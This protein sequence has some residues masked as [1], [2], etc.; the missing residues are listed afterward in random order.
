[1]VQRMEHYRR[2]FRFDQIQFHSAWG[3]IGIVLVFS[4]CIRLQ[5]FV[6][7]IEESRLFEGRGHVLVL[8]RFQ[9]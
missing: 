9:E 8:G 3:N 5:S 1:M 4:R 2:I 7:E 6:E